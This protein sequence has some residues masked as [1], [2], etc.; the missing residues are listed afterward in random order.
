[1][2]WHG[3]SYSPKGTGMPGVGPLGD[4]GRGSSAG[5]DGE[6]GGDDASFRRDASDGYSNVVVAA[7]LNLIRSYKDNTAP[8]D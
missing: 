1:M 7:S 5:D 4:V 6:L 3:T 8:T 2:A